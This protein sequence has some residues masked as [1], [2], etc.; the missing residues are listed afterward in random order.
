MLEMTLHQG[1]LGGPV[2]SFVLPEKA[3][4]QVVVG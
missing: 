3:E 2:H 4:D 1:T